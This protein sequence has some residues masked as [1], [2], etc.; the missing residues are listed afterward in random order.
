MDGAPCTPHPLSF[1]NRIPLLPTILCFFVSIIVYSG[2]F[3]LY[4]YP[5][6][7]VPMYFFLGTH[8]VGRRCALPPATPHTL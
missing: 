7:F 4:W 6:R 5:S 8:C 2:S 3:D 1:F